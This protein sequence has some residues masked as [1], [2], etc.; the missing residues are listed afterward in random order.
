MR[1]IIYKRFKQQKP[2]IWREDLNLSAAKK[3]LKEL[4][5]NA[6][7]FFIDELNPEDGL[8]KDNKEL[9]V[10]NNYYWIERDTRL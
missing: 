3:E 1:T 9:T 4:Y 5:T 8:S 6:I 2:V 10:C 7:N